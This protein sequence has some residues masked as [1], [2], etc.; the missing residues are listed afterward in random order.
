MTSDFSKKVKYVDF[1]PRCHQILTVETRLYSGFQENGNIK[2]S[3]VAYQKIASGKIVTFFL[4]SHNLR[5]IYNNI[6]AADLVCCRC[7]KIEKVQTNQHTSHALKRVGK[8]RFILK[9]RVTVQRE[10]LY[11]PGISAENRQSTDTKTETPKNRN[12]SKN[13]NF[14]VPLCWSAGQPVTGKR[15]ARS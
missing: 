2:K 4:F 10:K 13:G 8:I 12:I 5:M 11:P 9:M 6:A 1:L 7:W 14:Q 15:F 3:Q